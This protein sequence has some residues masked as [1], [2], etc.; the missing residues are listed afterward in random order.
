[1]DR[2]RQIDILGII[3]L[4]DDSYFRQSRCTSLEAALSLAGRH[5]EEGASILDIGACSTRPGA[6]IL[7]AEEEWRRLEPALKVIRDAF[8]DVRISIDTVWSSVV[9]KAYD[10]IGD[11][12][13]NDISAGEDD[14][15]ILP[16]AGRLGLG[17]IAMHKRGNPM[18]MSYLTDYGD[19]VGE[20]RRYF[21]EFS[22][23]A[24]AVGIKEW[25]LDPG[26]GFAKTIGQNYEL[27]RSLKSFGNI[28][29]DR[30]VLVGISRKSMIYKLLGITPEESLPATQVLHLKALENGADMLR[31]HDVA[32]AAR[33][34]ALYRIIS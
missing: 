16:A 7:G 31:V 4:T 29:G 26:F 32:E 6:Q 12:I 28:D 17:Y 13:V 18:T 1:M 14:P 20:V 9:E 22:V 34:I 2:N 5:V 25:I 30:R 15:S 19:V 21:E 23:K 24:A 33:T 8:P 3:N 10:I 11:F 27:L